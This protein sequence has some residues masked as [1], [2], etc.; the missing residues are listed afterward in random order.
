MAKQYATRS[1]NGQPSRNVAKYNNGSERSSANNQVNS[2]TNNLPLTTVVYE[3]LTLVYN[4]APNRR[5]L[6]SVEH[7][8]QVSSRTSPTDTVEYSAYSYENYAL[9]YSSSKNSTLP[10]YGRNYKRN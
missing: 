9:P 10:N 3:K 7:R 8:M 6:Q 4:D 1:N 2:C 5:N